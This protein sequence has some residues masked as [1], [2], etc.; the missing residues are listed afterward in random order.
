MFLKMNKEQKGSIQITLSVSIYQLQTVYLKR[1]RSSIIRIK[2]DVLRGHVRY[3]SYFITK[4]KEFK[5]NN[6]FIYHLNFFIFP[7]Q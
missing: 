2:K 1:Y 5:N 7:K 3:S 6:A 4:K